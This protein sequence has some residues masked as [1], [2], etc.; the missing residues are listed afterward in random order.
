MDVK[1]LGINTRNLV[2]SSQDRDYWRSL[3]NPVFR[4]Q[5]PKA[6]EL[7]GLFLIVSPF[8]ARS[9]CFLEN[10]TLNAVTW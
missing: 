4:A 1:E 9:G 3:V 6:M 8:I 5:V 7:V 10:Q 2:D